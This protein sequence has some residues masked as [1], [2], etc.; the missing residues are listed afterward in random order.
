MDLENFKI[1]NYDAGQLLQ[2][3]LIRSTVRGQPI[4]WLAD[5][6]ATI[7]CIEESLFQTIKFP[8]ELVPAFVRSVQGRSATGHPFVFKA[9]INMPLLINDILYTFPIFVVEKLSAKAIL[10]W[11]FLQAYQ[12][13]ICTSSGQVSLKSPVPQ[14]TAAKQTLLQPYSV[15]PV[16][17]NSTAVGPALV[18]PLHLLINEAI[19]DPSSGAFPVFVHNP[20]AHPLTCPRNF[21]VASLEPLSPDQI[22]QTPPPSASTLSDAKKK[23]ITDNLKT[24]LPPQQRQQL[25]DILFKYHDAIS[26]DK[27]DLGTNQDILHKINLTTTDPIHVKQFRIPEEHLKFLNDYVT[28]LENKHCIQLSQSS[29]NS[30][31]FMVKKKDGSL[32]IV[33]DF[34]K[35]NQHTVDSK[36]TIKDIQDCIDTV[37]RQNSSIFTSIDLTSGFWQQQLHPD[38]RQFTAFT[39]P[40]R[41][42]YEWL[43]SCMGLRTS[44]QAFAR[45]TDRVC[46]NLDFMQSYIDD[47]LVHSANPESHLSHI[48][49][50]LQRFI[51]HGLKLNIHKTKFFAHEVDYLGHRLSARGVRPSLQKTVAI[52]KYP[53]PDNIRRLRQFIGL[54]NYFRNYISNFA[55]IA[56]RLTALLKKSSG[57]T[58]GPLPLAAKTAF[59]I[60]KQKLTSEPILAYP[61]PK[62]P[63]ILDVDAATGSADAPG[64]LGAVLLQIQD[65]ETRVVAYASRSLKSFETNYTPFLLE[66]AAATWAI[67]HFDCYLRGRRFE[68]R[69]D[70]K[71]LEK[72][73]K[74]HQKTINRL[75]ELMN[76]YDFIVSYRKGVLNSV[77]DAL[78]RNAIDTLDAK[79]LSPTNLTS[80]QVASPRLKALRDYIQ[81]R[82]LPKTSDLQNFVRTFAPR[83][84]LK[85]NVLYYSEPTTKRELIFAPPAS[86]KYLIAQAHSSR[87]AGHAGLQKTRD[88]LF[89]KYFAPR[90]SSQISQFI[91][92]CQVCQQMQQPHTSTTTNPLTPLPIPDR[93]NV[94]VHM[95][96]IGPLKSRDGPKYILVTTD[97]YSKYVT[98]SILPDKNAKTVAKAFLTDWVLRFSPPPQTCVTDRGKEFDNS[99]LNEL[100]VLLGTDKRLTAAYKPSTNSQAERYNRTFKRLMTS[101]LLQEK[102][103]TLDWP[104]LVA[105]ATFVYNCHVHKISKYS[106]FFLTHFFHPNLPTFDFD[107]NTPIKSWPEHVLTSLNN[108]RN[109]AQQN[110]EENRNSLLTDKPFRSFNVGDHVLVKF[111]PA[112]TAQKESPKGNPKFQPKY[113][114]GFTITAKL[115]NSTFKVKQKRGK[116]TVVNSERLLPHHTPSPPPSLS[117][118]RPVTRAFTRQQQQQVNSIYL[119]ALH[120]SPQDE[121]EEEPLF[122]LPIQTA[123]PATSS[124]VTSP[125]GSPTGSPQLTHS[126]SLI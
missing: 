27:F 34:R 81:F 32:R 24:D 93:P 40:G 119:P 55:L 38:S 14:L 70:H 113:L 31:V 2:R 61:K 102:A 37:G 62:D 110:M 52:D 12:A 56:G 23:Y 67:S 106:P 64:G 72:V 126:H 99:M 103:H 79:D 123:Q 73:S 11:D 105:M 36:Y 21:P 65:G 120:S 15:T 60:L 4:S 75:Q 100:H 94:R 98:S 30:P 44:P 39:V 107:L 41:G 50:A 104:G 80:L 58:K 77:P 29:Y 45:L 71:P 18:S 69:T 26:H 7:S 47:C 5:T 76:E 13:S 89:L 63:F 51:K 109:M 118:S 42:R 46:H 78:S 43:K 91:Q 115:S 16:T 112:L 85:N 48:A 17:V 10:G 117:P 82:I 6:G 97:A 59:A 53:E 84:L 101:I 87:F 90:I 33:Q 108:I 68:L 96:L 83:S 74:L 54:V 3:P 49:I 125:V 116:E 86:C 9:K 19:V 121:E 57:W 25:L 20:T 92:N 114:P 122:T 1:C 124:P 35:L 22:L 95:D 28:E 111:P 66:M 88:R 8:K